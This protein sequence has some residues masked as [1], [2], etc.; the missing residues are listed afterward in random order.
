MTLLDQVRCIPRVAHGDPRGC[1]IKLMT[2][3]E[4]AGD[5][6]IVEVYVVR[7]V[8]GAVR[9]NHYHV[10]TREWFTLISGKA[11]LYLRDPAYEKT[12]IL[13]LDADNPLTVEIP[14]G[15][16]HALL[17]TGARD[18]WMIAATDRRYDSLDVVPFLLCS[19]E[20]KSKT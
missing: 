10:K 12:Q 6:G 18:M 4:P 15:L 11:S 2:G 16:A 13:E 19:I 20:G 17:A 7:S 9:G 1:L 8:P 14:P 5:R 3:L